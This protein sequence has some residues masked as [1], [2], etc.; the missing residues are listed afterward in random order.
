MKPPRMTCRT[1]MIAIALVALATRGGMLWCR[2]AGFA[3]KASEHDF[4][5]FMNEYNL[6]TIEYDRHG[7][8]LRPLTARDEAS[9]VILERR[10]Q[11]EDS[12]YRKYRHAAN[13]PWLSVEPDPSPQGYRT[14]ET[15]ENPAKF[16]VW[17]SKPV[18]FLAPLPP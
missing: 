15:P 12:L 14:M 9:R 16:E 3:A 1:F 4:I 5:K 7:R 8:S 13:L 11:Y 2:S 10:V 17:R 6:W 18:P